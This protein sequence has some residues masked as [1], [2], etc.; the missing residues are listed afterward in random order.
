MLSGAT[1]KLLMSE[2]T[3]EVSWSDGGTREHGHGQA[4]REDPR[5]DDARAVNP[6]LMAWQTLVDR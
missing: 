6:N 1:G 4:A 3:E 2:S 5:R